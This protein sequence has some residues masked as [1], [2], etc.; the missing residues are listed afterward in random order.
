MHIL[1]LHQLL[2]RT[3]EAG[4]TQHFEFARHL[5]R[6]GHRVTIL[7]GT[8]S[9]LTGSLREPERA[10]SPGLEVIDCGVWGKTHRSFVQRT[11]GFLS[12]MLTSFRRGLGLKD[13]DL[14]WSTSPP[15]PQ[16][17]TAWAL[18]AMKRAPLVFEVRDLWPSVAVELGVLRNPML[19]AVA[20]LAERFLYRR[21]RRVVVNSP[22]FL[23]YLL[24]AP[25]PPEKLALVPNG[26]DTGLFDPSDQGLAFRSAH[27]LEGKFVALYAGAH[28]LS[29]DLHTLLAAADLLRGEN[30]IVVVLL[31]DGKEKPLLQAEAER[32]RLGNVLFLPP[33]PKEQIPLA[34]AAADCGLAILRPIPLFATTFP[35]KV[36]DYM[37]AG[38]PVVLAIEGVIRQVVEEAGAGLAVAPGDPYALARA[39]QAMAADAAEAR[40]MGARGRAYVT[41][42]FDRRNL[43][44]QM[45]RVLEEAARS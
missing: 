35:N 20:R 5:A 7:A 1:L 40:R 11:L 39:I 16:V 21:A 45:E 36:F 33:V 29:N 34:L 23:P 26:A 24:G 44:V 15:L 12:F 28:G 41:A 6:S 2:L 17:L 25:V 42:S 31:G 37:A 43:A 9:Y 19:I 27:G 3:D 10:P 30:R 22:G 8:R 18:A 14:V 13:V 32:M 4:M 38:R